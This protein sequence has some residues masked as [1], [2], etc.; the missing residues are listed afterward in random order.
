MSLTISQKSNISGFPKPAELIEITGTGGLE[1]QDRVLVNTLY[2]FA[3]DSGELGKPGARWSIPMADLNTGT[4]KG[5]ERVRESLSRLLGI[6]V[7]V[8]YRAEDGETKI[9]QT[10]LFSHFITPAT[11]AQGGS[12]GGGALQFGIPEELRAILARSGRWGRIRAEI[13]CA[14]SSKYAI[15][16]YEMI[17]LRANMDNCTEMF[18][19]ERFRALLGVPPGSYENGPDF[20]RFVIEPA[21]VEINGL[22]ELSCKVELIR[23]HSR[24]PVEKVLLGWGLKSPE[25]NREAIKEL[26]R[27]KLGRKIRL[28]GEVETVVLI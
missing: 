6:Q 22:S 5:L 17:R 16:L 27:S 2:K 4:H 23:K 15:A 24:A 14:M 7:A 9:L 8:T 21:T 1:T 19:L 3:H 12:G 26:G 18:T 20:R 11:L 25:E 10:V 13:V 28:R